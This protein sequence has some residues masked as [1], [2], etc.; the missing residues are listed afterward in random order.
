M[1][2]A[3]TVMAMIIAPRYITAAEIA[4]VLLL[5]NILGPLFVYL[6][7]EFREVPT[8]WT[9]AG[10]G[11]LLVTLAVHEVVLWKWNRRRARRQRERTGSE[12]SARG[13]AGASGP[14]L[15]KQGTEEAA[16]TR[17]SWRPLRRLRPPK[18][19]LVRGVAVQ[20]QEGARDRTAAVGEEK[21]KEAEATG[22]IR[23]AI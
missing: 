9:L 10:G 6:S 17:L 11:M 1:I 4:L 8:A 16:H 23:F 3:V 19:F 7:P 20:E 5:E 22:G 15:A 14:A 12:S 21:I 18:W 2:C 13:S